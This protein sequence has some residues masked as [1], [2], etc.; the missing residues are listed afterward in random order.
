M[1]KLLYEIEM[2]TLIG[3][4]R[5]TMYAEIFEQEVKGVLNLMKQSTPF[6]GMID[7]NGECNIQGKIISLTKTIPYQAA[8]QLK[9][10]TVT[11]DL[12][13][14]QGEFH[15]TGKEARNEEIL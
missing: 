5:G 15:I 4:K 11:L 3:I 12:H 10:E 7:R 1:T 8:G 13:T 2:Q 6:Y 14:D 9:R